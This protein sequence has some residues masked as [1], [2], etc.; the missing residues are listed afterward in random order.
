MIH[1]HKWSK[2]Q[3]AKAT[4]TSVLFP[5]LGNYERPIQI[6]VCDRCGLKKT[7]ELA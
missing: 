3:D 7:R 4:Y 6:R 5:K 1:L 2:W